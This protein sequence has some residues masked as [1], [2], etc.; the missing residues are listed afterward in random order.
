[1]RESWQK[2]RKQKKECKEN[3]NVSKL[4]EQTLWNGQMR[5]LFQYFSAFFLLSETCTASNLIGYYF[6][7]P[8]QNYF[9]IYKAFAIILF[10]EIYHSFANHSNFAGNY[11]AE[12]DHMGLHFRFGLVLFLAIGIYC[13]CLNL[14]GLGKFDAYCH[15][16]FPS[17][18]IKLLPITGFHFIYILQL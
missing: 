4:E 5:I 1:M 13:R 8:Q 10:R 15:C 16:H 18:V 12:N 11:N 7:L 14:K 9:W 17:K 3:K 6:S 2:T